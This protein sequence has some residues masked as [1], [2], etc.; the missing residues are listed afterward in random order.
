MRNPFTIEDGF[1]KCKDF[2]VDPRRI[3]AVWESEFK[4]NTRLNVQI[5]VSSTE[6]D[7][8]LILTTTGTLKQFNKTLKKF[9]IGGTGCAS[10]TK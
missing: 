5:G 3:S 6:Q 8:R 1:I 7:S 4:G 9:K 10:S 2:I